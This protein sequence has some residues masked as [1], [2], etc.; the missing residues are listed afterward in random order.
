[1]YNIDS[2]KSFKCLN[3][4]IAIIKDLSN[5]QGMIGSFIFFVRKCFIFVNFKFHK[6]AMEFHFIKYFQFVIGSTKKEITLTD[7]DINHH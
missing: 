2:L 3:I 1:M 5:L 7:I 6:R 4:Y